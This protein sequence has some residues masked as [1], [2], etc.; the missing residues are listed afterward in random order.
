MMINLQAYNNWVSE[1]LN[2]SII[3]SFNIT[4]N[5]L[6]LELFV[7]RE[8]LIHQ[9]VSGNKLRKL[10]YNVQEA[11]L[12]DCKRLVTFGGAFSNHILATAYL[13]S[14]FKIP[15]TIYVRGDELSHVS[16]KILSYCYD[17]GVRLIFLPREEFKVKKMQSGVHF[18]DEEKCWFIPEGGANTFGIRGAAEIIQET[19]Y[20]DEYVVAQGTTTTSLGIYQQMHES[21][22]LIVVPALNNFNSKKEMEALMPEI[23]FTKELIVLQ[24][25]EMGRYA[26]YTPALVQFAESINEQVHFKLDPL[27][28]LRALYA[29]SK[30]VAI[31][32]NKRNTNKKVLFV[33]TGGLNQEWWD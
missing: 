16:N 22:S 25:K 7:K 11:G 30:F 10:K 2:K 18:L 6:N 12:Q 8:D 17:Q 9:I 26:K 1:N 23:N 3:E 27:Y 19:S 28:T 4:Y 24:Y 14:E 15:L 21:S 5:N 13:C 29:Y 33:H 32:E 31:P 20:F